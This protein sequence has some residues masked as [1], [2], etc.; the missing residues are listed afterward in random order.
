MRKFRNIKSKGLKLSPLGKLLVERG[1]GQSEVAKATGITQ[2]CINKL[3]WGFCIPTGQT[4]IKLHD[5]LG[6]STD[7][8]LGLGEEDGKRKTETTAKEKRSKS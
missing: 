1:I 3:V 7:Y 4:L 2:A 5:F 8:L 6:V